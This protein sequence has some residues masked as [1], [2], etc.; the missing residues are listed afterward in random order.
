MNWYLAKFVYQII[1]GD[2]KHTPQFDEQLRLVFA[3]SSEEALLKSR[4]I[5]VQEEE[6]FENQKLQLVQWKFIDVTELYVIN[7]LAD[8]AEVY[9]Q[10][11]ET[12]DGDSY[13]KFV[14]HKASQLQ[15][16]YMSINTQ[17]V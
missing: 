9:S 10:V 8:G 13:A 6:V 2:G 7:E 3:F 15:K 4:N 12:E 1:C 16:N 11:K 14:Q 5:G 17:T